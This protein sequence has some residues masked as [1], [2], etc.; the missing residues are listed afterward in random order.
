MQNLVF[1]KV[2]KIAGCCNL[3]T[4]NR[5]SVGLGWGAEH[6]GTIPALERKSAGEVEVRH[7]A[8]AEDLTLTLQIHAG[9]LAFIAWFLSS[10][11]VLS[12]SEHVCQLS[13][14]G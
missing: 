10:Q 12:S 7:Y 4:L 9:I 6:D 14:K 2:G 11:F 5:G 1:E 13:L 8:P 3:N